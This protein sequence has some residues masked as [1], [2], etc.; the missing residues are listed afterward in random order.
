MSVFQM[1]W[2]TERPADSN[3]GDE[4][5]SWR[6]KKRTVKRET[7]GE[8]TK[9]LREGKWWSWDVRYCR[10]KK[11]HRGSALPG[12]PDTW[13]WATGV[14]LQVLHCVCVWVQ[15]MRRRMSWGHLRE[16]E[17]HQ[18]TTNHYKVQ[19]VP[20]IS[21]VRALMEEQAQNHHLKHNKYA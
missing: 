1:W 5:E 19:N 14:F 3:S 8:G 16:G 17:G 9:K 6:S 13:G 11:R 15:E 20:Q 4:N 10:K 7:E 18:S 2:D 12:D 21:E